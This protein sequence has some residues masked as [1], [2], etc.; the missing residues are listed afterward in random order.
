MTDNFSNLAARVPIV[1]EEILIQDDD[2]D[3]RNELNAI[4]KLRYEV[5]SD[6]GH[7]DSSLFPTRCWLDELDFSSRHW[8][9]R[10]DGG[11][12]IVA[13]GRCSLHSSLD[14]ESRDVAL[15]R[16]LG[17][18]LPLPSVDLGRLV[19][20]KDYRR[21][22]IGQVLNSVRIEAA[23]EMQA[24]SVMVTASIENA[25]LLEKLGFES[26]NETIYFDDRPGVCFYALQLNL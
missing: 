7:I 11:R 19:V 22:G 3:A 14:D 12:D 9:V 8:V 2:D 10:D 6:E 21:R 15:W 23:K 4:G 13:A 1:A 25:H 20:R 16:R 24:K 5:W 17:R 18:D 26:L